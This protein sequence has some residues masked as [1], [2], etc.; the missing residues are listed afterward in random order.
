MGV[1]QHR[2]EW[3]NDDASD[4]SQEDDTRN[5]SPMISAH[6]R[7]SREKPSGIPRPGGQ[8]SRPPVAVDPARGRSQSSSFSTGSCATDESIPP[9]PQ[10]TR[11]RGRSGPTEITHDLH[12]TNIDCS[13]NRPNSSLSRRPS[14][15]ARPHSRS[16][17]RSTHLSSEIF[18]IPPLPDS[19]SDGDSMRD[20]EQTPKRASWAKDR[21]R[22]ATATSTATKSSNTSKDSDLL[23]AEDLGRHFNH[24]PTPVAGGRQ[25]SLKPPSNFRSSIVPPSVIAPIPSRIPSTSTKPVGKPPKT[26]QILENEID[27]LN[28]SHT[29]SLTEG[30]VQDRALSVSHGGGKVPQ[31]A[32][33]HA[34]SKMNASNPS[35]ATSTSRTENIGQP[36][37]TANCFS[38]RNR[39]S[40][41]RQSIIHPGRRSDESSK[42]SEPI[43]ISSRH[44]TELPISPF[45][46]PD[47]VVSNHVLQQDNDD[48]PKS[49]AIPSP[50][51]TML[52]GSAPTS[53]PSATPNSKRVLTPART[54]SESLVYAPP[55][56]TVS[57]AEEGGRLSEPSPS[58]GTPGLSIKAQSPINQE[59]PSSIFQRF[60]RRA[61]FSTSKSPKGANAPKI[62]STSTPKGR[63]EV[64][65]NAEESP[66]D[67]EL[68]TPRPVATIGRGTGTN[69]ATAQHDLSDHQRNRQSSANKSTYCY[70]S[71]VQDVRKPRSKVVEE[72]AGNDADKL[73]SPF[74]GDGSPRFGIDERFR[75][76]KKR[77]KSGLRNHTVVL[78]DDRSQELLEYYGHGI[79]EPENAANYFIEGLPIGTVL[80]SPGNGSTAQTPKGTIPSSPMVLSKKRS[81]YN[82][83]GRTRPTV[84]AIPKQEGSKRILEVINTSSDDRTPIA[85]PRSRSSSSVPPP[86]I[87]RTSVTSLDSSTRSE[88]SE[89][90]DQESG[91]RNQLSANHYQ[92]E[93][94]SSRGSRTPTNVRFA[95]ELTIH[96]SSDSGHK[97]PAE[98][99][100][101]HPASHKISPGVNGRLVHRVSQL[102]IP[103]QRKTNS[104]LFR[105]LEQPYNS[106]SSTTV[107]S[108]DSSPTSGES[109]SAS[110]AKTS[111]G[112]MTTGTSMEG[113]HTASS[114]GSSLDGRAV[115]D[116]R[117]S[118][119][120]ELSGAAAAL[121]HNIERTH[122]GR[123]AKPISEDSEKESLSVNADETNYGFNKESDESNHYWSE[124]SSGL[125][126]DDLQRD[127]YGKR[128]MSTQDKRKAIH[129]SWRASLEDI[130]FKRLEKAYEPTELCR[131]ELI[132]EFHQSERM[133]VETMRTL[134]RL[135][136]QP[137][138]TQ[139]QR[140]W[141]TGLS[142]EV[143][144]LFDW[145]DDIAHLHEQLLDAL[146][147]MRQD[148]EQVIILFSETVQPF[149]PL[150]EL[151][152]PYVVRMD[153]TVK[154][155]SAMTLDSSSHFGEFVRM[156][157]ALA[158]CEDSLEDMIKR[159]LSRVREYIHFFE[160]LLTFT[161]RTHPD[162]F[163]CFSL[164]HSMDGMMQVLD[165]VKTREEEYEL[166]KSLLSRVSGLPSQFVAATRENRLL[167][168]GPLTRVHVNKEGCSTGQS[169][170]TTRQSGTFVGHQSR[171]RS[172]SRS[173][174]GSCST[175]SSRRSTSSCSTGLRNASTDYHTH[176]TSATSSSVNVSRNSLQVSRLA[177]GARSQIA[178]VHASKSRPK[179][180]G[181]DCSGETEMYVLVFTNYIILTKRVMVGGLS[182]SPMQSSDNQWDTLESLGVFRL[183]GVTDYHGR[184][185]HE[186]LISLDLAPISDTGLDDIDFPLFLGITSQENKTHD[187]IQGLQKICQQ[188][189]ISFQ[190]CYLHTLR[191]ISF[192][193][194]SGVATISMDRIEPS[195]S[196]EIRFPK[197]PSQQLERTVKRK[198]ARLPPLG[199]AEEEREER[200]FWTERFNAISRE[201][202]QSYEGI[203]RST[204]AEASASKLTESNG[205]VRFRSSNTF[206]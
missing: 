164:L 36:Q 88:F 186:Y 182:R 57:P 3:H 83:N 71:V 10:V 9:V 159:P 55:I 54:T 168:Q 126:L 144:K 94:G 27:Y 140:K 49:E 108:L 11:N 14:S 51:E 117:W 172:G 75:S 177:F 113:L 114:I 64:D 176:F 101:V 26:R 6:A 149:I 160:T 133:F 105:A 17:S 76:P 131:Q 32:S 60:T 8:A 65:H 125:N 127:S 143:T 103:R 137:L 199:N 22:F 18:P 196:S 80:S 40:R 58:K 122:S 145:L 111:S 28:S 106:S 173:I 85:K 7:S 189:F 148:H 169:A 86:I 110:D 166:T 39:T 5:A 201:M 23:S 90:S 99:L 152:Q 112:Y 15:I 79:V 44:D 87:T 167:A 47:V 78:N 53:Q 128:R 115:G 30:S 192:P 191:S 62:Q 25:S 16:Y 155:I 165:E 163:S 156:K 142:P 136:F 179:S 119:T 21:R 197:S 89:S 59:P 188:W 181:I 154:Q 12:D 19:N 102:P 74:M 41:D 107:A 198:E 43:V 153:E 138:R 184:Y 175:D 97:L 98:D 194:Q 46:Q 35:R 24:P 73:G 171:N 96:E 206:I 123:S 34:F 95:P 200:E 67:L 45:N 202:K 129:E 141:I 20:M 203:S 185:G 157:H 174:I 116:I 29:S 134:I 150:M 204:T 66:F 13:H 170:S 195:I 193:S 38:G 93:N 109:N 42:E 52:I 161:P 82:Y 56:H 81:Q 91:G 50:V 68:E 135:F 146:E 72:V 162:H 151:Y 180:P 183:L 158:D 100:Q 63:L 48:P 70:G 92:E 130:E 37:T 121:F 2:N 118:D 124:N 69:S 120:Q 84:G 190:Q 132:W 31:V 77:N 104:A 33:R 205:I 147:T 1:I 139:D 187:G 61:S 178:S 4:Y